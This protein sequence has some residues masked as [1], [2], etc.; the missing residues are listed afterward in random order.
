MIP[1]GRSFSRCCSGQRVPWLILRNM[2]AGSFGRW[3]EEEIRVKAPQEFLFENGKIGFDASASTLAC[4]RLESAIAAFKARKKRKRKELDIQLCGRLYKAMLGR[5]D[6]N[7]L[8]AAYAAKFNRKVDPSLERSDQ[9]LGV[10]GERSRGGS[11]FE[12]PNLI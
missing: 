7:E 5:G 2:A 11:S 1:L 3:P 10:L 4:I 12:A 8:R 6:G 9:R